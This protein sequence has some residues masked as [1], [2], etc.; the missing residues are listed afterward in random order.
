ME[1][2]LRDKDEAPVALFDPTSGEVINLAG[3]TRERVAEWYLH[4]LDWQASAAYAVKVGAAA[5]AALTD[6]EASLSV[7]VEGRR[8]S[9]P[10]AGEVFV[11]DRPT[12]R[13]ALLALVEEGEISQEA[14]D[15]ACE[16]TGVRCPSCDT[17]IPDGGYKLGLAALKNLRKVRRLNDIIDACGEYGQPARPLKSVKV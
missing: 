3:V 12:L 14:A 15:A 8:V 6:R 5:F 11:P 7:V 16:P 9:V 10:G 13:K 4:M 2:V 1:L 17:F